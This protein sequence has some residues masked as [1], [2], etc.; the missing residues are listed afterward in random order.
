MTHELWATLNRK[1]IEY[2][3]SV[4]LQDLVDQQQPI[5]IEAPLKDMRRAN[6]PAKQTPE[7]SRL[8][9]SVFNLAQ[10]TQN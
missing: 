9:N 8:I 6:P 2:L 4:T 5:P 1:M 7:N 3:D 10:L